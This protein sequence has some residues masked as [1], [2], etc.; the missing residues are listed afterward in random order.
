MLFLAVFCGFLAEYQL[1][2]KIDKEKAKQAIESL[3]KCLVSDTTQLNNIIE[4]NKLIVQ[5]L[6]SLTLLKNADLAKEENKKKFYEHGT[7][8]FFQDWY[9]K[10][11]DAAME[12]LKSSGTL[13][14]I[15][16]QSIIDNILGYG[17]KNKI[18][19]A[20]EADCYFF[21]KESLLDF[22][23]VIDLTHLQDTSIVSLDV[24]NNFVSIRYKKT[25]Q[26]LI[27]NDKEKLFAVFNNA[28]LM[29]VAIGAYVQFM[30]EQLGYCKNLID[31]LKNEYHLK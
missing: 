27:S 23:K 21:F 4:S 22:K 19:V 7:V 13:R 24:T 9:F 26:L 1:E 10:T 6:D 11:N 8:G 5:N 15:R 14:L 31:L 18:T 16:K 17:L 3:V 25:Y 29:S 20:Q 28:A 30:Q 2:H 12:Q